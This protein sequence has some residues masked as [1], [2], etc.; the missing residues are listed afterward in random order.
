MRL[1]NSAS[2]SVQPDSL[3]LSTFSKSP[4]SSLVSWACSA[5]SQAPSRSNSW[6]WRR[7]GTL[8]FR[9]GYFTC[10]RPCSSRMTDRF[11]RE[12]LLVIFV[13]LEHRQRLVELAPEALD[14]GLD[15]GLGAPGS[16]PGLR[17]LVAKLLVKP[18]GGRAVAGP[19]RQGPGD[20]VLRST[21]A[22]RSNAQDPSFVAESDKLVRPPPRWS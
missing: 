8:T 2:Q 13:Q 11:Q 15:Q 1:A 4:A 18:V 3:G 19:P 10:N 20:L 16:R 17:Q 12:C 9:T 14:G 21:S 7:P 22:H 5:A 6:A